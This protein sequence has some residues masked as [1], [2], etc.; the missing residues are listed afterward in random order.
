MKHHMSNTRE[1]ACSGGVMPRACAEVFGEIRQT[2]GAIR[3]LAEATH[4][5]VAQTN[6]QVAELFRLLGRQAVDAARVR[7][8]L[9]QV[10]DK[11]RQ[12]DTLARKL[13]TTGWRLAVMLA[14]AVASL[15]GV[16]QLL[17]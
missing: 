11:Q 14:G 17:K 15:L 7:A 12:Q 3:A 16:R 5:Q 9:K 13:L 2:L 6:G 1:P 4:E 10:R 8:E